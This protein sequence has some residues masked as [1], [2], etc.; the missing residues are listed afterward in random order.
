M[1]S[2]AVDVMSDEPLALLRDSDG[3]P[4]PLRSVRAT[5]RLEGLVFE[6]TVEQRYE[7][8]S[9]RNLEAVF[10][11]P[12]PVRAVLRGLDLEIGGR[13]CCAVAVARKQATE[14]YERA[15]DAGDTAALLEHNGH[16]LYTAS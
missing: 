3:T 11:L 10:T 1:P 12:L 2:T 9:A 4:V 13:K 14:R 7:N 15:I 8:R 6:R 16:G 5:G